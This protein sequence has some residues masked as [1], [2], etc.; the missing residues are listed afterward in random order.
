MEQLS[1]QQ[2]GAT[3]G[4]YSG[5]LRR[6][7]WVVVLGALV[8]LGLAAAFLLVAPRTYISTASVLVN[9]IGGELDNAVEGAR[10]NSL[11]NLDTEAQLV[12]S[13]AVSSR[14][15]VILQT[16]EIVGQLVQNV[17]VEVPPNTNVLRI[18]FTGGTAE[19]AS[20]G[21][22]AYAA[23]YL[24]NRRDSADQ[25]LEQQERALRQQIAG[26]EAQLPGAT[27]DE[28]P[29]LEASLETV[30]SR[31]AFLVGNQVNPGKVISDS[32]VPRRPASPNAALVLT[33]GLALGL[34]LGL[35]GLIVLERRDGRCY[36]WRSV[37]RRLNLPILADIPG[38]A[39]S[40]ATLYPPH[41]AGAEAFNQVRNAILSGLDDEPATLVI[42]APSPGFGADVVVANL[43]VSLA[44][45]GHRTTV[46]VA[47]ES[48]QIGDLLG[49]PV[50]E[51]L[52]EVLRGR[53]SVRDA[54]QTV[55]DL[56]DL[57]FMAPGHGLDSEITDLEGSGIELLLDDVAKSSHFVLIR[58]RATDVAADAQFFGR[59]AR[60]A[61]PVIEIGRTV[62]DAV[63]AGVR[64]WQLVGTAVPGAVSVPPFD[65]PE[66]A[67]PRA[68]A[69]GSVSGSATFPARRR[70]A[71]PPTSPDRREP[72]LGKAPPTR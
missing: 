31:L 40:P 13:Q 29:Q 22:A 67:R 17:S 3:L 19:E 4:E 21:A 36:D 10:T 9:P 11:V 43:A 33:S 51:G 50:T 42:A 60:A 26:L 2:G 30:N 62:R 55:P 12:T 59:H 38:K 48:S 71:R 53:C 52:T 1:G 15:K 24:A 56:P 49:M 20:S 32:L 54:T 37:E 39:G 35:V 41:T 68:V 66:P 14:A 6:R 65:A 72:R 28:L 61:L 34:L 46:V 57:A 7:W 16:R 58:A 45:S 63:E 70:D 69:M 47:D 8:G 18:S 25:L 23:A 64:Q 44:R 27:A 5:A